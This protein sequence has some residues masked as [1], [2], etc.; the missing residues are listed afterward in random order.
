MAG[1]LNILGK[2][3][4]NKYD[5]D[6]KEIAPIIEEIKTKYEDLAD[7]TNDEIRQQT[8]DLK[9]QIN[10]FVKEE[11]KQKIIYFFFKKIFLFLI[12]IKIPS[13]IKKDET[14]S[15]IGLKKFSLLIDQ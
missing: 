7:L 10:D 9:Q 8:I 1:L 12:I 3:F 15:D 5:K 4:G 2:L 6:I 14:N 13:K 11:R